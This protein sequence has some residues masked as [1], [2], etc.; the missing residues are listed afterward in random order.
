[1]RRLATVGIA[2][3]L[4][5]GACA[6]A[7]GSAPLTPLHIIPTDN[8][9][10]EPIPVHA[11]IRVQLFGPDMPALAGVLGVQLPAGDAP[12]E[13]VMDRYPQLRTADTRS[14]LEAT[15]VIDYD[16]PDF[17]P[18]RKELEARGSKLSRAQL[19]EYVD[20]LIA[21]DDT[22]DWDL[23]SVVA[24]RRVGDCSEHAVL[25]AALARMQGTPARV[26]LG[27]ALV[28]QQ[29]NHAAFGH[30]W[31]EL[32]EDGQWKVADAA[33]HGVKAEVRYVPIG[34][35]EDEGMGYSMGLLRP[36]QRWVN[37]VVVLGPG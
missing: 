11:P 29:Q 35:M 30:A 13:Y 16:E 19:V 2:A 32:L 22:R 37:R 7:D 3:L 34:L 24:R 1:M 18:L 26:A 9:T 12:L 8:Q 10:T 27:V 28:S 15:F 31:A 33:L 17:E 6:A 25:T 14:W 36:M 4:V 21:K 23:A 20:R 5:G